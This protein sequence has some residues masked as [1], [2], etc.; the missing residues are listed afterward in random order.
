MGGILKQKKKKVKRGGR[1]FKK[2]SEPLTIFS[3]I[4][5]GL[6]NKIGSLKSEL[7]NS[8]AAVFKIQESHFDKK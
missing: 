3:T 4:A 7:K 6:K 8:K 2:K 5:A 1:K